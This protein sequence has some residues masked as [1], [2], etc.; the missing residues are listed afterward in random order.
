MFYAFTARPE[1]ARQLVRHAF[2]LAMTPS[3]TQWVYAST[4]FYATGDYR[5]CIAASERSGDAIWSNVAWRAAARFQL[6]AV[7]RARQ[8]MRRFFDGLRTQWKGDQP[9]TEANMTR[10]LLHLDAI[11]HEETWE[12]LRAGLAGAGAPVEGI[13]HGSR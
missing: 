9:A 1:K 8:E 4:M 2:D 11:E 6:G 12:R 7:E 13:R 10:W 3:P 5:D